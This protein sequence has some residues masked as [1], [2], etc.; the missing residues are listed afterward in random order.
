MK[1]QNLAS[2]ES[3]C[4]KLANLSMFREMLRGLHK[5]RLGLKCFVLRPTTSNCT[6][7]GRLGQ[8]TENV[9]LGEIQFR[10]SYLQG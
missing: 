7:V 4:K 3:L 6:P 2:E 5:S 1:E 8:C 10:N 9:F